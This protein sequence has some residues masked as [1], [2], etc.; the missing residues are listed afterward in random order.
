MSRQLT[1]DQEDSNIEIG[2]FFHEESY[3]KNKK[4][5]SLGNIVIDVIKKENGQLVVGEVKKTSKFKQSA[6][7]QL[8]FYLKQ[9]KDLGIQASGSLMFPKEKKR[10]FFDR[11]KGGRI[12]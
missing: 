8:L 5:I 10:G 4:E 6:R 2:R 11:R 3:K 1:P 12:K 9:L 7:M